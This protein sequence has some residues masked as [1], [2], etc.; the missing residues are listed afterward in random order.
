MIFW[1]DL[2]PAGMLRKISN[3][4]IAAQRKPDTSPLAEN[5][6]DSVCFVLSK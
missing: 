3:S 4:G 1:V 5:H 6:L 2:L